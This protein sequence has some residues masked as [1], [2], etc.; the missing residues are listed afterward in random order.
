MMMPETENEGYA[1][2]LRQAVKKALVYLCAR[3]QQAAGRKAGDVPAY[4]QM[5]VDFTEKLSVDE[6]LD[7]L[8]AFLNE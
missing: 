3:V 7:V 8:S 1:D 4:V 5:G 6:M 2:A